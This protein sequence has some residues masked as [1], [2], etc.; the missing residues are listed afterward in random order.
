MNDQYVNRRQAQSWHLKKEINISLIISVIGIAITMVLGYAD[1]KKEIALIQ[2][3]VSVLHQRDDKNTQD[4]RDGIETV[5]G[6]YLR[7]ESKLDRL[8]ENGHK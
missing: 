6:Q 3:D 4:L 2:A 1:I 5:S 7:L 8:I